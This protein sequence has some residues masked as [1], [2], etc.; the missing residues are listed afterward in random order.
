M[1]FTGRIYVD[2]EE[3]V[4]TFFAWLPV[5]V[6]KYPTWE[7][8]WLTRVTVRQRFCCFMC[9]HAW[10]DNVAFEPPKPMMPD[11]VKQALELPGR[12]VPPANLRIKSGVIPTAE[13]VLTRPPATRQ[14][15]TRESLRR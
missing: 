2:G 14:P 10:W 1:R 5:S 7:M 4:R 8:R 13:E 12:P 9:T 6:Y 11:E 15:E 3:R